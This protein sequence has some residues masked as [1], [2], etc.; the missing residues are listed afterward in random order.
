MATKGNSGQVWKMN[1]WFVTF[2]FDSNAIRN[3]C[4]SFTECQNVLRS[5][6][7][8][9]PTSLCGAKSASADFWWSLK[10]L[11]QVIRDRSERWKTRLVRSTLLQFLKQ[12]GSSGKFLFFL[13]ARHRDRIFAQRRLRDNE[14]EKAE[15]VMI[16][17][18]IKL[19]VSWSWTEMISRGCRLNDFFV[20]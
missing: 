14:H 12:M 20:F 19:N 8:D 15:V 18:T 16:D 2:F 1:T 10:W 5:R 3:S 7:I 6:Q 9:A 13:L 4:F 17:Q 11:S